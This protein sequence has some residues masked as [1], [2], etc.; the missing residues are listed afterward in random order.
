MVSEGIHQV[1]SGVVYC[2]WCTRYCVY[3]ILGIRSLGIRALCIR[4]DLQCHR[5]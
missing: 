3:H 4:G 1:I 2:V 5:M